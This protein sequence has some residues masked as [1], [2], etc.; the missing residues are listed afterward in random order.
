MSTLRNHVQLVGHLGADPEVKKF[1]NGN[2]LVHLRLATNESFKVKDEWKEKTQWHRL[3]AWARTAD[4]AV[5]KLQK[6]SYVLVQGKLTHRQFED[7]QGVTRYITEVSVQN[8]V[9]LDHQKKA[10]PI[11]QA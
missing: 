7:Q 1:D 10:N 8:F 6:G 3:V 5:E 11:A 9:P 4:R 2:K